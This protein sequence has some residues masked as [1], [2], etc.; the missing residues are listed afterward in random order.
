MPVRYIPHHE[1]RAA[2]RAA[3][4]RLPEGARV[5]PPVPPPEP[6]VSPMSTAVAPRPPSFRPWTLVIIG[7]L[8]AL[9]LGLIMLV[10]SGC[11]TVGTPVL[12]RVDRTVECLKDSLPRQAIGYLDVVTSCLAGGDYMGCLVPLAEK[13]GRDV[14]ACAVAQAGS[15]AQVRAASAGPG[16]LPN[17]DAIAEHARAYLEA[18]GA[19]AVIR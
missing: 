18:D 19:T 2:N 7:V 8:A 13:A 14:I 6:E 15:E 11:R 3:V 17:Q 10:P 12:E 4:Y 5:S 16:V 1:R 9:A